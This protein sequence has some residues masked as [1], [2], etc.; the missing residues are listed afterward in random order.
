MSRK[1]TTAR[2]TAA[3]YAA[4]VQKSKAA[5]DRVRYA[6]KA[7]LDAALAA[8]DAASKAARA[9]SRAYSARGR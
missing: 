4:A 6:D 5:W 9:T 8:Y 2:P 7:S 3:Q 1:Q